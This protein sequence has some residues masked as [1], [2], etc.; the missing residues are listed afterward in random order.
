MGSD[1][2]SPSSSMNS[3]PI[4]HSVVEGEGDPIDLLGRDGQNGT[5][6]LPVEIE[7]IP[8]IR[9]RIA[10]SGRVRAIYGAPDETEVCFSSCRLVIGVM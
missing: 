9:V 3:T 6:F 1:Y 7:G 8:V 4:G 10:A 2:E 5:L